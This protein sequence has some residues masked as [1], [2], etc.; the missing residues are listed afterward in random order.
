MSNRRSR[1]AK[2]KQ[3]KRRRVSSILGDLARGGI[4]VAAVGLLL[5]VT[6]IGLYFLYDQVIVE[7]MDWREPE[8]KVTRAVSHITSPFRDPADQ[9]R[10]IAVLST[11]RD[12][13]DPAVI[14]EAVA[15]VDAILPH[16]TVAEEVFDAWII[17]RKEILGIRAMH[18][19]TPEDALADL[20]QRPDAAQARIRFY[21]DGKQLCNPTIRDLAQQVLEHDK[22]PELEKS[23]AAR[24]GLRWMAG[25]ECFAE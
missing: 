9:L 14:R 11:V 3:L 19:E 15:N 8:A 10:A 4:L 5:S 2:I 21:A 23:L 17:F 24:V 1:A 20:S 18:Y 7:W 12:Q 22:V 6:G 16:M 25:G 13:V